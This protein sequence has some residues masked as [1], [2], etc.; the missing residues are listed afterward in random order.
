MKTL[1]VLGFV[2]L[3]SI[4][5]TQTTQP[6]PSLTDGKGFVLYYQGIQGELV[7]T[8]RFEGIFTGS[9]LRGESKRQGISFSM[10]RLEGV[11]RRMPDESYR[12]LTAK[13][14]GRVVLNLGDASRRPSHE[15]RTEQATLEDK[16][17]STVVTVPVAFAMTGTL[18]GGEKYTVNGNTATAVF[19]AMGE[20]APPLQRITASGNVRARVV[21]AEGESGLTAPRVTITPNGDLINMSGEGGVNVTFQSTSSSARQVMTARLAS[22]QAVLGSGDQPM[23][24]LDGDGTVNLRLEW[25]GVPGAGQSAS[26]LVITAVGRELRYRAAERKLTLKD[27][28]FQ[29]TRRVADEDRTAFG[30]L[31][32]QTLTILFNEKGEVVKFLINDPN[33]VGTIREK[34]DQP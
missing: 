31:T 23:R 24:S 11:L 10:S 13:M 1:V 7:G 25:T 2:S 18:Q 9:P 15:L 29:G 26:R 17:T 8:D 33:G 12:L 34:P 6:T 30:T 27:A 14:S 3:I 28:E 5:G 32:A 22:V 19:G 16:T 20:Q 21:T 4:A